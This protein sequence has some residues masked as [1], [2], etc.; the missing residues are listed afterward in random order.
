MDTAFD[1]ALVETLLDHGAD[2]AGVSIAGLWGIEADSLGYCR[3]L[4]EGNYDAKES[5]VR[6]ARQAVSR[7]Q[8]WYP[9]V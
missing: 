7:W 4:K 6:R 1:V 3:E 2:A 9:A 8:R 5:R